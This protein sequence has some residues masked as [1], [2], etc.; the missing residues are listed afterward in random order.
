MDLYF[1]H[2]FHSLVALK[3]K[4]L[5]LCKNLFLL[6]EKLKHYSSFKAVLIRNK[7]PKHIA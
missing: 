7:L 2:R 1:A 3:H 6:R 5:E 4:F